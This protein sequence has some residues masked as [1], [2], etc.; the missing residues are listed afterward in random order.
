METMNHVINFFIKIKDAILKTFESIVRF[1]RT[2]VNRVNFNEKTMYN[3]QKMLYSKK[4]RVRKKY[5]K[6]VFNKV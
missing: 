1:F 3:I 6:L 5:A 2:I 4:L